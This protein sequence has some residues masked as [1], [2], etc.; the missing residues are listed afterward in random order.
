MEFTPSAGSTLGVEMELQLLDAETLDLRDEI[1]PLLESLAETSHVKPEVTQNTVEVVSKVCRNTVELEQHLTA[2]SLELLD[3]SRQLGLR[4]CGAGTHPFGRQLTLITPRPRYL[5][6]EEQAGFR[7]HSQTTFATHVHIG[8]SSGDEAIALMRALKPYLPLLIAVSAN[9]PFWRG[10]D[11]GCA[12]YRQRILAATRSYGVPPSFNDWAEFCHFFETTQRAQV[13]ETIND[14]HWDIR[15]RPR[16]GTLEVRT[17]DQ[18]ATVADVVALAGF[19]RV[20]IEWLRRMAGGSSPGVPRDLRWWINKENHFQASRLGLDARYIADDQ[21]RVRPL[22]AVW[23]QV[24]AEIEPVAA[25][26]GES[27]RLAHL[28]RRIETGLGYERQ[29]D[30]YRERASM[31]AVTLALAEEFECAQREPVSR[32]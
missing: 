15:P 28:R 32:H 6:M 20:L 29:R 1:L 11:T 12:S 4:L 18:Q 5:G 27:S 13:F 25:E 22:R 7:L 24:Y 19:V 26:L 8:M 17:M 14:I 10:F 30:C 21:G 31:R 9:S 2:V 3:K 23:E 16:F